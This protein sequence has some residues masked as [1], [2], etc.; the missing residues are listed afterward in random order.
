MTTVPGFTLSP[1]L[2]TDPSSFDERADQAWIDM[3]VIIPAINTVAGEVN[4]NATAA[5][6]S[7]AAAANSESNAALSATAA[8]AAATT[9][10]TSSTSNT[11]ANTGD[12]TFTVSAGKSFVLGQ[13]LRVANSSTAWMAGTVKSY[14]GTTLVVTMEDS[15]GSGTFASWSISIAPRGATRTAAV[16]ADIWAGTANTKDITPKAF[17]DSAVYQALTSSAALAPAASDG[18][19]RSCTLAHS[20]SVAAPSGMLEGFTYKLALIGNGSAAPTSWTGVDTW[21]DA[22]EPDFNSASGAV[23]LI[24]YEKIGGTVRGFWSRG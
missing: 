16:A 9:N 13:Y 15:A 8:A 23:N 22:G 14:S 12:K 21:G 20:G 19:N 17:A 11:I 5:A 7:A 2:S 3:A 4:T 1:P 10:D 6:A 24:C 18:F